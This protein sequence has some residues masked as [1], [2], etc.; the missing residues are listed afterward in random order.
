MPLKD[1]IQNQLTAAD[2]QAIDQHLA[3]HVTLSVNCKAITLKVV[4]KKQ[5]PTAIT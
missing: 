1:L 4:N 2:M 5:S 3:A